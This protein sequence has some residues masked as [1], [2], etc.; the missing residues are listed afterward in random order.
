MF[1]LQIKTSIDAKNLAKLAS[2]QCANLFPD[3][4]NISTEEMLPSVVRSMER[5]AHCFCHIENRYFFDGKN[6]VFNHLHG[7][8]YAMWLY[9]LSRQLFEDKMPTEWCNKLFLLNKA[10]HGCDIFFEVELPSI[11]LLVHPLGTVLGR[12]CYSDF[13]IAYQRCG[14][15]S[16][17]DLY[18]Q[19]GPH[20]T[21][22]PGSSVLGDSIIGSNVA[23]AAEALVIDKVVPSDSVYFGNPRNHWTRQKLT[24]EKIWRK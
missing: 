10:L 22:K 9:I 19:I 18:P 23:I 8:Q 16:N 17:H 11:F 21:L 7:D 3:G 15:G 20:V 1:N 14:V 5:L 2:A 13:F 12:G 24:S 6:V 4:N